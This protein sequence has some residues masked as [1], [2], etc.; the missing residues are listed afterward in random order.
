MQDN[1]QMLEL[2]L[3]EE[4]KKFLEYPDIYFRRKY[5]N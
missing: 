5:K 2:R 3:I 4:I 1:Q